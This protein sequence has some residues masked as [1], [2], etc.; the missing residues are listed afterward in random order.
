[1][2]KVHALTTGQTR[3]TGTIR[4]M[5]GESLAFCEVIADDASR[6]AFN[7]HEAHATVTVPAMDDI[8]GKLGYTGADQWR[9]YRHF[10][11]HA[12]RF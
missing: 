3:I 5:S 7:L 11:H 1:M 8:F 9:V 12:A 6:V 4:T 10:C 2:I